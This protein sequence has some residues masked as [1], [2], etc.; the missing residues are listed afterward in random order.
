MTSR[1]NWLA[2]VVGGVA[3]GAAERAAAALPGAAFGG[4]TTI[5]VF[6]SPTCGCCAKWVT[7]LQEHGFSTEVEEVADVAPI[8]ARYGVPG[9]LASCHTGI[10]E[11]YVLEG[12]VPAE[13]IQRLLKERPSVVGLAV[14]G[15]P[16]GS[17]GM[18]MGGRK[19][20]FQVMAFDEA[21][22]SWAF[23]SH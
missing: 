1:R 6:R 2:M 4:S 9:A 14:P 5:K 21:G 3:L 22:K 19:D 11:G 16:V 10:V 12:H 13:D 18:E 7:H 8:K 15:M 23:A 20:P 17:P